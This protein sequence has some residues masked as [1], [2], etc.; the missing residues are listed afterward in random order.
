MDMQLG[1][2]VFTQAAADNHFNDHVIRMEIDYL[3]TS[4]SK[5]EDICTTTHQYCYT[6]EHA[7]SPTSNDKAN[8]VKV[9]IILIDVLIHQTMS[10]L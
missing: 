6:Y 2:A 8:L 1:N 7:I 10:A 4:Y 5:G 9:H 3:G